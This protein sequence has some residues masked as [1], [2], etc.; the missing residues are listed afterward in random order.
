MGA[1]AGTQHLECEV[2][3]CSSTRGRCYCYHTELQSRSWRRRVT[4]GLEDGPEWSTLLALCGCNT[5]TH[6][7][8]PLDP[9]LIRTFSGDLL[10]SAGVSWAAQWAAPLPAVPA[11]TSS[12][13]QV[14]LV[15]EGHGGV[16]G[17]SG[18]ARLYRAP[19]PQIDGGAGPAT[20]RL[21]DLP[22]LQKVSHLPTCGIQTAS[23]ARTLFPLLTMSVCFA[24]YSFERGY[25]GFSF[26]TPEVR[27]SCCENRDAAVTMTKPDPPVSDSSAPPQQWSSLDRPA[28][29]CPSR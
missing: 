27:F 6:P 16:E 12:F 19:E 13:A 3:A 24:I 21:D 10:G 25:R 18:S 14:A 29:G 15:M 26:A 23:L 7:P 5:T 20:S 1:L 8:T 11:R 28:A 9:T 17:S 22:D 2:D 4:L